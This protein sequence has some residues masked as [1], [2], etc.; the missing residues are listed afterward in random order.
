VNTSG[1]DPG[2]LANA[3]NAG[4]GCRRHQ[5]VDSRIAPRGVVATFGPEVDRGHRLVASATL[6]AGSSR[7][8]ARTYSIAPPAGY[9]N[10]AL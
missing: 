2:S 10:V 7:S 6:A 4:S 1:L 9:V 3:S 5:V 8:S